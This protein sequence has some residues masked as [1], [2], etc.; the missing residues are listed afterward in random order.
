MHD[1]Q[2]AYVAVATVVTAFY[3]IR[4]WGLWRHVEKRRLELLHHVWANMACS[5]IG[6]ALVWWM[7]N[8]LSKPDPKPNLFIALGAALGVVGFLPETLNAVPHLLKYLGDLA[9]KKASE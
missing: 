1:W 5:G 4:A 2:Y 7:W 3:G 9:K 6:F 8:Q